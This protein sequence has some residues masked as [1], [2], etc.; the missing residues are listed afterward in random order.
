MF[1]LL[2]VFY[3]F[4]H[5]DCLMTGKEP[6]IGKYIIYIVFANGPRDPGSL[7]GQLISKTQKLCLMSPCLT[8]SIIRYESRINSAIQGKEQCL[9]VHLGVVAIEKGAF[10]SAS[11]SYNNYI[12]I[13][14]YIYT[15]L[16]DKRK[17]GHIR[18]INFFPSCKEHWHESMTPKI[19][20]GLLQIQ[21]GDKEYSQKGGGHWRK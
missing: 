14:I 19:L 15:F 11:T 9:S 13:Y 8:P 7:L 4:I 1:F 18:I 5:I 16:Q 21:H 6:G 2:F 10:G 3:F 12:Y 17:F 20:T